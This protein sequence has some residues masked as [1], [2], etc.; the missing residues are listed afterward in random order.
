MK[1]QKQL[2]KAKIG[3]ILNEPFFASAALQLEYREDSTIETCGVNG[4][5]IRYNPDFFLSFPPEMRK[6]LIVHEIMHVILLHHLRIGGKDPKTW[7]EAC[8]YVVNPLIKNAG[9]Q[10]P[11]GAL[12][13]HKFANMSAEDVYKLLQQQK[14]KEE[15]QENQNGN[16]NEKS[17]NGPESFGKV[18]APPETEDLKQMEQE[19]KQ[20]ALSAY[21]AA[22]QAGQVHGGMKEII[23]DLV[24][25]KHDWIE[26]LSRFACEIAKND[27][28]WTKPNPRYVPSGMYLP[29]LE[30]LEI[31]RVV[32]IMDTSGS[33]DK[34]RLKSV[35]T[36]MKEIMIIFNITVSVIHCD[37]KVQ[38]VEELT[39]DDEIVPVGR[40]GTCFQP[41]FDYVTK[42]LEDTKA[43]VYFTDGDAGDRFKDPECPVLWAVYGNER[44]KPD[45]GEVIIVDKN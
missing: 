18:E 34:E 16:E 4:K 29:A 27:Y 41:A 11:E 24:E 2:E 40:G 42:N 1:T 6:T 21:N 33:M 38:K 9:F 13:N 17:N 23:T 45:F 43:I 20:M 39:Q 15:E 36:E 25:P 44:F 8:D 14:Q 19:A 37:T 31:I 5:V 26:T 12:F 22:K 3:L 7:N 10:L 28:T 32:F 30:S 35:I